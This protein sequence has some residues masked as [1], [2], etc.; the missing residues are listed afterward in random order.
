VRLFGEE[1]ES[2]ISGASTRLT[3][4][5]VGGVLLLEL[6]FV[7][8]YVGG[9]HAPTPHGAKLAVV[10][11]APAA[12]RASES[13]RA[14]APGIDPQPYALPAAR[15]AIDHGDV[16]GALVLGA[17]EDR[18]LVSQTWNRGFATEVA[19]QFRELY[20]AQ[21]RPLDVEIVK[22]LPA[23]DRNGLSPFYL[24]VGWIVGGYLAAVVLALAR[25]ERAAGFE[26][27]LARVGGLAVYAAVSGLLG[28]LLV[29]PVMDV[30]RGHFF[31][32]WGLGTF[33]VLAAAVTT[34]ALE[35]LI[36]VLGVGLAIALFVVLGNPSS[37]AIFPPELLPQ[38]W[39]AVGGYIAT[40][41]GGRAVRSVQY[42]DG[43]NLLGP[44]LVLMVYVLVGTAITLTVGARRRG[45]PAAAG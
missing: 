15:S 22:P 4:L 13:I 38:P 28:A 37:G 44:L 23:S 16:F 20:A 5:L 40:G 7:A 33:I 19:N 21:G 32:L 30:L 34:L 39:R 27:A 25:G 10:G 18:L 31:E 9:L 35:G 6:L 17:E 43:A 3:V 45:A 11:P 2:S 14:S 42:F 29:G 41:A 36:G 12:A 24:V 8:S 1:V 26:R